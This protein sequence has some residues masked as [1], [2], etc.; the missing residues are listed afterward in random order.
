MSKKLPEAGV[1]SAETNPLASAEAVAVSAKSQLTNAKSAKSYAK[2]SAKIKAEADRDEGQG[3][4]FEGKLSNDEQSAAKSDGSVK[5]AMADSSV[6]SDAGVGAGTASVG[7]Q[8]ASA[9]GGSAAPAASSGGSSSLPLIL[10]G[11]AIAGGAGALAGGGGSKSKDVVVTPVFTVA[12]DK[13]SANEGDTIRFT[14]SGLGTKSGDTVSYQISGI[15]AEDLASGSLTGSVVLDASGRGFVDVSLKADARTEGSETLRF[16]LGSTSSV[17]VAVADTSIN[18]VYTLT[19]DKPNAN[20]GDTV[21]FTLR[22]SVDAKPGDTVTYVI[23]GIAAEDLASGS[24]TGSF[25]LGQDR[26]AF[27][28]IS[29]AADAKT[30]AL[31]TLVMT[32][33]TGGS[34]SV[35]V[36]D[37]S[38]DPTVAFTADTDLLIGE[39]AGSSDDNEYVGR[40]GSTF[41]ATGSATTF[42]SGDQVDGG[43]GVNTLDLFMD[44]S[45]IADGTTVTNMQVLNLRLNAASSDGL[46]SEL[47]L[48]QW[49]SSLQQININSNK[50]D[51]VLRD[52]QVIAPVSI[53]DRSTAAFSSSYT[54][55]Y[56]AGVLD[57]ASNALAFTIDNV[58]GLGGSDV[59]ID[60]GMETVS[61]AVADRLDAQYASNI[62]LNADDVTSIVVTQGRA[63]QTFTMDADVFSGEDGGAS[64]VSTAFAGDMDLTSGDLETVA[65]GV[66]DDT[67][68]IN[69]RGGEGSSYNLGAGDNSM[70]LNS[71]LAGSITA[72]GGSDEVTVGGDV[73]ATGI[74]NVG[75]GNNTVTVEGIV[76]GQVV[77]GTGN[78]TID[79][80]DTSSDSLI[81]AGNGDNDVAIGEGH[82]GEIVTGT[83]DDLV[84]VGFQTASGSVI[85]VGGG[86]NKITI[87]DDHFGSVIAGA[88]NDEMTVGDDLDEGSSTN[89]GEGDNVLTVSDDL[90]DATVV[91]G[92]GDNRIV[93]GGELDADGEIVVG[94]DHDGVY[95]SSITLGDG[96]NRVDIL[97][98]MD[99]S[100]VTFGD[101]DGNV[102]NVGDDVDASVP[103]TITF[104]GGDANELNIGGSLIGDAVVFGNGA[105]NSVTIGGD[106]TD[107]AS[108]QLGNGGNTIDIEG[109]T[110]YSSITL[111]TGS[112]TLTADSG[113][114][115]STVNMGG[116]ADTLNLGNG[117]EDVGVGYWFPDDAEKSV[118][119][120]GSGNDVVNIRSDGGNLDD[121]FGYIYSG[122]FVQ[123]GIG[124]DKMVFTAETSA[125]LIGRDINQ[126]VTVDYSEVLFELGQVIT[127]TFARGDE[128]FEVDYTVVQ[129][130]FTQGPE[131]LAEKVAESIADQLNDDDAFDALFTATAVDGVVTIE[132]DEPLEDF[133]LGSSVGDVEVV[134]LSD[135]EI[136]SVET[137]DLVAVNSDGDDD[138]TINADFELIEGTNTVNLISQVERIEAVDDEGLNGEYTVFGEDGPTTFELDELNGGEAI[139]VSGHETSATGNSQVSRIFVDTD[140]DD[141]VVGDTLSVTINDVTVNY[142][143]TAADLNAATGLADANKIAASLATAITAAATAA[144]L[145][146]SVDA[147]VPTSGPEVPRITLIGQPGVSFDL[148]VEHT[149]FGAS[150]IDSLTEEDQ[151]TFNIADKMGDLRVG[152]VI[153]ITVGDD[154]A[155]YTVT[156]EDCERLEADAIVASFKAAEIGLDGDWG[157]LTSEDDA[158]LTVT[159]VIDLVEE[160]RDGDQTTSVLVQA[161]SDTDDGDADVVIAATLADDATDTTMDLTVDGEGDFDL[162]I[163]GGEDAGFNDLELTLGD[164][165]DHTIDTGGIGR[166]EV[167]PIIQIFLGLVQ[168]EDVGFVPE[169]LDLTFL[170]GT[171]IRITDAGT[172]SGFFG[173]G[174]EDSTF[175][176]STD[177]GLTF[178]PSTSEELSGF[179]ELDIEAL[180]FYSG[181]PG[182]VGV[183]E[184]VVGSSDVTFGNFRD[185]I[186]VS[187]ESGVNT[188]GSDIVLENV[189]AHTVTSTS[190]ANITIDQYATRDGGGFFFGGEDQ[191]EG[192]D[193]TV[194]TGTGDDH[195][196]TLAQSALT[197]GS[198]IDLGSGVN[199]LSLGFGSGVTVG[200]GVSLDFGSIDYSGGL[201]VFE[202]LNDLDDAGDKELVMPG[203]VDDV[204]ELKVQ[205]FNLVGGLTIIGADNDFTISSTDDFEVFGALTIQNAAGVDIT[206]DL[207]V[208]SDDQIHIEIGNARLASITAHADDDNEVHI[209]GNDGGDFI[210]GDV[211]LSSATDDADF[212][213]NEN[214]DTSV[215]LGDL[216]VTGEDADLEIN[217]NAELTATF[218]DVVLLGGLDAD[219]FIEGNEDSSITLGS[220]SVTTDDANSSSAVEF[221]DNT[222]TVLEMGPLT[223]DVTGGSRDADLQIGEA[224]ADD[225]FGGNDGSSVTI[226]GPISMF[227]NDDIDLDVSGNDATSVS[228]ADGSVITL[229]TCG[230]DG[231]IDVELNRNE[232]NH[233]PLGP[234]PLSD[235][236]ILDYAV[237]LGDMVMDAGRRIE[238]DIIGN[239][240][241][242]Y[243][244]E[245]SVTVGD[246]DMFAHGY[247]E[248][249]IL[250]NNSVT[251]EIGEMD[252]R[253]ESYVE[254]IIDD[255]DG[256]IYDNTLANPNREEPDYA[257]VTIGDITS[258]SDGLTYFGIGDNDL[259]Q[260]T[261]GNVSL[262]AGED[263]G[264]EI[265]SNTDIGI[266]EERDAAQTE[267]TLGDVTIDA[268]GL[269]GLSVGLHFSGY[270]GFF[271]VSGP[272]EGGN[273][274]AIIELGDVSL[275]GSG[276]DAATDLV[277]ANN[278]GDLGHGSVE[279]GLV[280]MTSEGDAQFFVYNNILTGVSGADA[281]DMTVGNVTMSADQDANLAISDNGLQEFVDEADRVLTTIEFGDISLSAGLDDVG[282]TDNA[283]VDIE[284]NDNIDLEAGGVTLSGNNTGLFVNDN[285]YTDALLGDVDL[286]ST[287]A[288]TYVADVTVNGNRSSVIEMGTVTIDSENDALIE[289]VDNFAHFEG[290]DD[291]EVTLGSVDVQADEG[292]EFFVLGNS[293]T[294]VTIGMD[295]VT[296]GERGTI[297]IAAA[298]IGAYG[299]EPNGFAVVAG[300]DTDVVLGDVE[301]TASGSGTESDV[302][303]LIGAVNDFGEDSSIDMG[304]LTVNADGDGYVTLFGEDGNLT[305]GDIV[306]NVGLDVTVNSDLYFRVDDMDGNADNSE[307][308]KTQ[309]I[310]LSASSGGAAVGTVHAVVS[311]AVDLSALTIFGTNAE[312]YLTGD[313]GTDTAGTTAFSLDLSGLDGEFDAE[314]IDYNPLGQS[315]SDQAGQDDGTY[316]ETWDAD[317]GTDN[318][319]VI[320]GAGDMIYNAAHSS[321]F[322]GVEDTFPA[323]DWGSPFTDD[324]DGW[325]SLGTGGDFEPTAMVQTIDLAGTNNWTAGDTLTIDYN[326]ETYTFTV[327]AGGNNLITT[328]T[329]NAGTDAFFDD[330]GLTIALGE[331]DGFTI[332]GTPDG[333]EFD[334]ISEYSALFG[335]TEVFDGSSSIV[336]EDPAED[337]FGQEAKEAFTFTGDTVGEIVI[338]GF[339]PGEWGAVNPNN[340]RPTDRLD[341]SQFD[342]NG[343][344]AGNGVADLN[345]FEIEIDDGD[346]YFKDVVITYIGEEDVE[347]GE[348]RL[349][350]AGEFDNAVELVADSFVFG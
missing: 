9:G 80:S 35:A 320:I 143:V 5:L 284:G 139:T 24:L 156:A 57:G 115:T 59:N 172:D 178:E 277:I 271:G 40:V 112:D 214:T 106:V 20:E 97:G 153:T 27:V 32:V 96:T 111:G 318:V 171:I 211:L 83:G 74:I 246:V 123:G 343:A 309:T 180:T 328:G 89:L 288:G 233:Q 117:N 138:I 46:A 202:L 270:G 207:L 263:A 133:V 236:F 191:L 224:S 159:R 349:V 245:L 169:A 325:Y 73:E 326:N 289:V 145:S 154:E 147:G 250:D 81:N 209:D 338:G 53:V 55:N 242:T 275:T 64:F 14:V 184:F 253:A 141:H 306:I 182:S 144:G 314:A 167:S 348:I 272:L 34:T 248:L 222:G 140:N 304:D 260:I 323:N 63:G 91:V 208:Q 225:D 82:A 342:W 25:V 116:G 72:L 158:T 244:G 104:G 3:V 299:E 243:F 110:R 252:L 79:A 313:I 26:G 71:N 292:A 11:L 162:A 78:D 193:I 334:A 99:D 149:R 175:E 300:E 114:F 247:N 30:E 8:D 227:A 136:T 297:T 311:D 161:A 213:I 157:V 302:D 285:F 21:R 142:V 108:I 137:L 197:D 23:S 17:S 229:E 130:D 94:E 124:T 317:F 266:G 295:A 310:T 301:L 39:R 152:D 150:I 98:I 36:A 294:S 268:Q 49:D 151:N 58:N 217:D 7:G 341:F 261:V 220:V 286:T 205:D 70:E 235:E 240:D 259:A 298:Y 37:T 146:V 327:G 185:S 223:M 15:S 331:D 192:D 186:T 237:T 18:P 177:N 160:E 127:V 107:G 1:A 148:E 88:G 278:R 170:D 134:Q 164:S 93:I 273:T 232:N 67:L 121:A 350:G 101:G 65:L 296:A 131:G 77:A 86:D 50:S 221:I 319:R 120:M 303:V 90:Y 216:T 249:S 189:L 316:V 38:K 61:F 219:V 308:P 85:N 226:D 312:V 10:G 51:L 102:L 212:E 4:G 279:V 128:T 305:A 174:G 241:N 345:D 92:D 340:D 28:D 282:T 276:E 173:I 264:I 165:H 329:G 168:E 230:G 190:K 347:F 280:E 322:T 22:G 333:A 339:N 287:E 2:K 330:T 43:G 19:S 113:I 231:D 42:A 344:A 76:D 293:D 195:L 255:N 52:Q 66:G 274:N 45:G 47:Y 234:D 257:S 16:E 132:S 198:S 60:D 200:D 29:L 324:E 199:T 239:D 54:F 265:V 118:I 33:S 69:N 135:A 87:D 290:E 238:L 183:D 12:A 68:V 203:G 283:Q 228:L 206:G 335:S 315:V 179:D 254:L 196:I 332:T 95:G 204:K 122:G 201:A 62:N 163:L 103:G 321:W 336:E 44:P 125:R 256:R 105:S 346:G 176:I 126:L 187:D 166:G 267:V 262:T 31:E 13:T 129:G 210:V 269:A 218:G 194:T 291:T 100:D 75:N 48:T 109:N 181:E 119:D 337:N 6:M 281:H 41:F 307:A 188:T 251:V 215:F 84:T 155:T 56:A 258:V